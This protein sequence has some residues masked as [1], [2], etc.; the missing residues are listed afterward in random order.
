M[1]TVK[2]AVTVGIAALVIS[3]L[4]SLIGGAGFALVLIRSVVSGGVFFALTAGAEI[5]LK[6]FLPELFEPASPSAVIDAEA[7]DDGGQ[8]DIILDDDEE[9]LPRRSSLESLDDPGPRETVTVSS[10]ADTAEDDF[11]EEVTAVED[12]SDD[13]AEPDSFTGDDGVEELPSLD[14]FSGTFDEFT[15]D[16]IEDSGPSPGARDLDVDVMGEHQ[17]VEDVARAVRTVLKKDQKG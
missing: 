6:Q 10:S 5:L 3:F 11:V 17:N 8:V 12:F 7:E 1:F 16:S 15:G 2:T 4:M 9:P 14:N 13:S